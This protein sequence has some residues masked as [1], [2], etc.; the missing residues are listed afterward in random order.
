[1]SRKHDKETVFK[2]LF[3]QCVRETCNDEFLTD[4]DEVCGTSLRTR[5]IEHE[6]EALFE[7]IKD[8]VFPKWIDVYI[9]EKIIE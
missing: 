7:F 2:S 3:R 9:K 4:F 8:H 5:V 1:M 6:G